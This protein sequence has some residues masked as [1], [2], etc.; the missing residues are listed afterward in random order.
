[1]ARAL[2]G[3]AARDTGYRLTM[4]SIA[5]RAH[6]LVFGT[7]VFLASESMLFAGLL[8]AWFDLRG[9]AP[10]WPPAGTTV[11]VTGATRPLLARTRIGSPWVNMASTPGEVGSFRLA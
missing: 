6:P 5:V 1:M 9:Q 4:R 10:V 8:A 3:F 2:P 7:V 11:D